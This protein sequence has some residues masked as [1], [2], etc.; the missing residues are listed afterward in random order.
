MGQKQ[1][2]LLRLEQ[3]RHSL[4]AYPFDYALASLDAVLLYREE[5][6]TSAIQSLSSSI[7]KI[8]KA[9]NVHREA[10]AA[11]ILFQEAAEQER[12]SAELVRRLQAFLSKA[13]TNP[14]LRFEE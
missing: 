10:I 12:V 9:Q 4:E 14:K 13:R 2:A 3:V 11:V 5:G 6:R 1:E 8:F 7:L